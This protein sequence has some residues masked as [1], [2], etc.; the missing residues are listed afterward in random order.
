MFGE[1]RRGQGA[2][3]GPGDERGRGPGPDAPALATPAFRPR[4][5][6][7]L[8]VNGEAWAGEV[9]A[10]ETLAGFLRDR[11][12]LT[13][14]KIGC[15][16]GNCGACSVI[17]DGDLVYSCLVPVAACDGGRIETVEGLAQGDRLHPVQEAFIAEDAL[18][19]G[20]C[21]PGQIMAVKALLDREPRPTR[22]QVIAALAGNLC[23]C[24]AYP[25]I[26]KAALRAAATM[27]G[28]AEA[29][30]RGG[31]G[32]SGDGGAANDGEGGTSRAT[33]G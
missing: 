9:S 28:A 30:A 6:V 13:G 8:E 17:L 10:T 11:L 22:E 15:E 19:C 7:R 26:V 33:A 21:T 14:T 27:A 16:E 32:G 4:V 25:R 3:A 18:Q 24:G 5:A 1:E 2:P 29:A 12:G 31:G 20:F 23:R